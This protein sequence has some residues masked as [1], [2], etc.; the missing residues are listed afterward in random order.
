MRLR[1]HIT[2]DIDAA[3][4]VTAA[5]HQR[6]VEQLLAVVRQDYAN[7]NLELRERR[8]RSEPMAESRPAKPGR[9][10]GALNH[11]EDFALAASS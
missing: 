4:F 6:R 3:D 7:A 5:E 11:Y 8:E 9:P 10:T 1:A 2:I